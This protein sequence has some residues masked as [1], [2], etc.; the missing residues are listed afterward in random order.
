MK[1]IVLLILSILF[2][3]SSCKEEIV[4]KPKNLIDREVMVNIIYDLAI[5]DAV[6]SQTVNGQTVYP[7][8]TDFI[9]NKYKV[10][11]LTFAESTKYYASDS[12]DYKKIY[13][14][15]KDRLSKEAIK[16]NGGKPIDPA[17]PEMQQGVVN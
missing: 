6:K 10:D 8:S 3:T 1:K 13:D 7:K 16:Y 9:K 2:I 4:K 17:N 5:L 11:S 14:E 12:K 15:V